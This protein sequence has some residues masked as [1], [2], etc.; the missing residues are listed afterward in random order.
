MPKKEKRGT[1]VSASMD[2]TI[3]VSIVENHAHKKYN[4]I[5]KRTIKFK[6]HDESNSARVGQ[7]VVIQESR[8]YSKTKCWRLIE[9]CSG[10]VDSELTPGDAL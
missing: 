10:S 5:Q 9:V 8:P 1:V 6:A 2:K 7:Q 3:V 4:K